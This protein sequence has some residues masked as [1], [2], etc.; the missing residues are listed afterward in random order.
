[1]KWLQDNP[2]GMALAAV[3]GVLVLFAL[4]MTIVCPVSQW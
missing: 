3:G 2:L 1:M 4:G